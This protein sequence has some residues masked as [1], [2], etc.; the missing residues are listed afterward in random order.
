LNPNVAGRDH[1]FNAQKEGT[2]SL[3]ID[4]G[5]RANAQDDAPQEC[6]IQ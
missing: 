3:D 5:G 6:Q 2:G 1:R 4:I